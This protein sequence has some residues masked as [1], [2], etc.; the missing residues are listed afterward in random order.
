MN[1]E[2]E[3]YHP[4]G[5]WKKKLKGADP[6]PS[7]AHEKISVAEQ[8]QCLARMLKPDYPMDGSFLSSAVFPIT[9]PDS[10]GCDRSVVNVIL[11]LERPSRFQT[12]SL[13][14]KLR[15]LESGDKFS[16]SRAVL[17]KIRA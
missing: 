3:A 15:L 1:H 11:I 16:V 5:E 10:I 9:A 2:N 8:D 6:K 17:P 7:E 14:P 13:L 4:E 12:T